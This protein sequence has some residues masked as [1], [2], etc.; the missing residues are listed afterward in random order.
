MACK[1][2]SGKDVFPPAGAHASTH[3]P[4]FEQLLRLAAGT[5]SLPSLIP[6]E[7]CAFHLGMPVLS[8][9]WGDLATFGLLCKC[10]LNIKQ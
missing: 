4:V 2:C 3:V 7:V 1:E 6:V 5:F 9:S 10:F 8:S